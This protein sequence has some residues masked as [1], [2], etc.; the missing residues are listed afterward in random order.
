ME[1]K[2]NPLSAN[3][4]AISPFISCELN[5]EKNV[6]AHHDLIKTLTEKPTLRRF[7]KVFFT[8]IMKISKKHDL[9]KLNL[10][11]NL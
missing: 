2:K 1:R 6:R 5:R 3:L 10:L 7:Q 11:I 8:K 4:V 9:Y